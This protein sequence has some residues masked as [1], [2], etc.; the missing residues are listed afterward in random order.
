M[1]V[2]TGINPLILTFGMLSVLQGL[3]FV[4]T[5][6]TV[7][8]APPEFQALSYGSF[9]GVPNAAWLLIG[10]AIAAWA[11]LRFTSFGRYL[12]AVGSNRESA[13]RAGVST[14][15]VAVASYVLCSLIAAVAGLVLA[16]RLGTGYTLAGV[17]FEIDSIV[18]VVLGGTALT[19]GRGGIVGT[20]GGLMVLSIVNNALN[21]TAVSAYVQQIIKGLI[22]VAAVVAS[23]LFD[24][25]RRAGR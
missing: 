17:G 25:R 11:A 10:L 22:V 24:R 12:Y 8:S 16:A 6:R 4:Y 1:V 3:I 7:G 19:G 15:T 20:F 21:L 9:V 2:L 23:G 14:R 18:A 5:D 13:R